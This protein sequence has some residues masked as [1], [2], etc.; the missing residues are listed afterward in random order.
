MPVI[1]LVAVGLF[2][3]GIPGPEPLR[4][5]TVP[6]EVPSTGPCLRN[7]ELRELLVDSGQKISANAVLHRSVSQNI[8]SRTHNQAA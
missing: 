7:N 2:G 4:R 8:T 1:V 5:S 6:S 3:F